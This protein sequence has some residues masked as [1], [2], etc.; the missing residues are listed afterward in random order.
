M[1]CRPALALLLLVALLLLLGPCSAELNAGAGRRLLVSRPSTSRQ[2]K[3]EQQQQQQMRV[4]GR[5][6]PFK[7]AAASFGRRI[8][9]SGWN[10]IQN[11]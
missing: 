2:N 4:G 5:N 8:P 9:R 10:P 7:Q 6:T 3:A 1:V 11:R